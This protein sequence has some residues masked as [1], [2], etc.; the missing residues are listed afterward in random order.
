LLLQT[1]PWL[2]DREI[3]RR[4]GLGNKT[5]SRLRHQAGIERHVE[6]G[7][8]S[9][10][11]LALAAGVSTRQL[12]RWREHG[13]LPE[14]MPP[15]SVELVV[16][17]KDLMGR[18][19]NVDRVA[20]ALLALGWPVVS[21]PRVRT[22]YLRFLERQE[23]SLRPLASIFDAPA[24]AAWGNAAVALL[25]NL[26]RTSRSFQWARRAARGLQVFGESAAQSGQAS[27]KGKASDATWDYVENVTKIMVGGDLGSDEAVSELLTTLPIQS[28]IPTSEQV[29]MTKAIHKAI[30]LASLRQIATEAPI[31]EITRACDEVVS[32]VVGYLVMMDAAPYIGDDEPAW[33]PPVLCEIL[34]IDPSALASLGL[35]VAS[36]KRDPEAGEELTNAVINLSECFGFLSTFVLARINGRVPALEAV[37]ARYLGNR[38]GRDLLLTASDDDGAHS[39]N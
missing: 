6:P 36:F 35:L 31:E 10:E 25:T 4:V 18:Y 3:A 8:L 26:M 30:S 29:R 17:V 15:N 2:S 11:Q 24:D 14:P 9:A 5:V 21:E 34:N 23:Q 38:V 16:T 7:V 37:A 13:L 22:A 33:E 28:S 39:Q 20:L 27:T 1:E 32:V 12:R 19:R